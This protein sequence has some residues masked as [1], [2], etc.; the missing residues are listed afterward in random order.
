MP[1]SGLAVPQGATPITEVETV[2]LDDGTKAK[3]TFLPDESG[4][5]F[6]VPVVAASKRAE[7]S[8]E[9]VFDGA[10]STKF[11]PAAIP[12]TDIDDLAAVWTPPKE[13]TD[14]VTVTIKNLS[15]DD[16]RVY[17]A[18]LLGWEA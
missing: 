4:S 15:N 8:Y 14:K 18:Q 11:G 2:M 7:S 17:H 1:N 16:G 3:I 6:Y 5:T 12:P 9:I 13:F 10:Q